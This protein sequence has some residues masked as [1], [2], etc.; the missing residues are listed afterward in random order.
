VTEVYWIHAV[1][2][3]GNYPPSTLNSGKWLVFVPPRDVDEVWTKLKKAT[4]GGRLGGFSKVATARPNPNA[5]S[6]NHVICIYTYDWT[7]TADVMRIRD[8][9]RKLG[10]IAKIPYKSDE[11]TM[12]GKYRVRGDTKISK[13]YE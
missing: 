13:Y 3:K 2:Q 12:V 11:D 4:E 7:D 8:E 5:T 1:S 10:I 9:L 6:E